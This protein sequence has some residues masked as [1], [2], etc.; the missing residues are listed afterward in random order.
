M[1]SPE[2]P[3]LHLLN[4][5]IGWVELGNPAEARCELAQVDPA[6]HMHPDFLEVRWSICAAEENWPEALEAA[7]A[8]L[9]VAPDRCSGWIHQAYALRRVPEGGVVGAWHALLPAFDKFPNVALVSFNLACYACLLRHLDAARVWLK[10]ALVI[11]KHE[12]IK[13]M[14]L[15]EPDLRPLWG[16]IPQL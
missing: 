14:A 16:E 13:E 1:P 6:C 11:G 12:K 7:R 15:A 9:G 2:P 5:A 3:N 8:L 4:A 10:R